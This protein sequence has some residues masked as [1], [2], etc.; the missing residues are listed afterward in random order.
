MNLMFGFHWA[1]LLIVLAL[2]VVIFGPKRL[3]EIGGSLGR[4]IR[5]FRKGI[6]DFKEETGYNE[7]RNLPNDIAAAVTE[8]VRPAAQPPEAPPH[9]TAGASAQAQGPT[10]SPS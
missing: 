5:D 9:Q 7:I 8:P 10:A 3:P 6:G 1:E 4:G 2:A